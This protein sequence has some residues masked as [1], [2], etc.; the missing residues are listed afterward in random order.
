MSAE[1]VQPGQAKTPYYL[2][3]NT[4]GAEEI[5]AAKAVLDSG[6]MTM[7]EQV[8]AFEDEFA[9]W[10][11]AQAAV[12][13]NSGSSANL[14]AIDL[15]L[16]RSDRAGVL[17]AGDE[18]LV[19]ALS[20]PTTVWPLTQLGL[21]P[22]FVDVDPSTLAIDLKSAEASLGPRIKAMF[23]IHVL[24][25]V[26]DMSSYTE[27]CRRHGLTLIED[28]CESLGGHHQG[29]HAGTFGMVGTFS[30]Y[31]SHHISTI[32]G[33]IV[34]SS[35][36]GLS[37]DL[38]SARAHGW[39]RDRSDAETWKAK[40][41][42]IDERFLFVMPGYNLRPT[43]IQGAIGRVQLRKLDDMI[44]R[45][46][47]LAARVDGWLRRSSPWLK[48]LGRE[49]LT[50]PGGAKLG[51]Q[52]RQH[53]WMALPLLV[54]RDAP[55]NLDGLRKLFAACGVETRPIIAGNLARHPASARIQARRATSLA[56]CDELLARGIMIG[57][58]PYPEADALATL[59]SAIQALAQL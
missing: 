49:Y 38:R 1:D 20:W 39:V 23:L 36:A 43:E 19:P 8:R 22:V 17:Q 26:P 18:V 29:K 13:V 11:G 24:G 9:R 28:T 40:Y 21:V 12:M 10:T 15:T 7:G 44:D 31:F 4:L 50:A 34:I 37:D 16:R 33:G 58:H 42:E 14:L 32:E 30:C 2:A 53:S 47:Q 56:Q 25:L 57:C 3:S 48:L 51:R 41:P 6:R 55:T 5:E 35:D 45:R 59:E 52:Q 46:E 54:D 27:F